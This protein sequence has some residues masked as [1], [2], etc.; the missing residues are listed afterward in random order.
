MPMCESEAAGSRPRNR[1]SAFASIERR[2]AASGSPSA[3]GKRSA[4]HART[5]GSE[6]RVGVEQGVHGGLVLGPE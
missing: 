5:R 2:C 1:S 6:S 3:R 4:A